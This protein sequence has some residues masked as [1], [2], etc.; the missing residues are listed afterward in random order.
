MSELAAAR[1]LLFIDVSNEA[2]Y[3]QI[4]RRA[5]SSWLNILFCL[6]I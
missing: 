3:W 1:K 4:Q 6:Y 5:K 2:R